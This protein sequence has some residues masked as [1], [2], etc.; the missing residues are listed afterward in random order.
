MRGRRPGVDPHF[1]L[2][3]SWKRAEHDADG[4][5]SFVAVERSLS[6]RLLGQMAD[7]VS[8]KFLL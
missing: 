3:G 2:H 7:S 4:R 8:K 1:T 5:G 6:D